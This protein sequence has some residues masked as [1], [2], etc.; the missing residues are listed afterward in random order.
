MGEKL[1]LRL[2]GVQAPGTI[3]PVYNKNDV[4]PLAF[5]YYLEK[6][7]ALLEGQAAAEFTSIKDLLLSA[8][9]YASTGA[10]RELVNNRL[11]GIDFMLL[12]Y[13]ADVAESRGTVSDMAAA[14]EALDDAAMLAV[15]ERQQSFIDGKIA[16]VEERLAALKAEAAAA[17]AAS[18]QAGAPVEPA[19]ETPLEAS[20]AE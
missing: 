12:V 5:N 7:D 17:E 9:P 19:E 20:P 14:L 15:D 8:R 6:A 10:M 4:F 2:P 3:A 16:A 18:A 1:F 13:K 11:D